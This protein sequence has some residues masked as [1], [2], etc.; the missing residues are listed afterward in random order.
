MVWDAQKGGNRK[1]KTCEGDDDFI[2]PNQ[3][4]KLS[5]NDDQ[6]DSTS[7]TIR[8]FALKKAF[9]QSHNRDHQ[10]CRE[11]SSKNIKIMNVQELVK[12]NVT[13]SRYDSG[14][15]YQ[16]LKI[17]LGSVIENDSSSLSTA[18]HFPL[19]YPCL[20]IKERLDKASETLL[21]EA[22]KAGLELTK[23]MRAE[24]KEEVYYFLETMKWRNTINVLMA[25]QYENF[26]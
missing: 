16:A 22:L 18:K 1:R 23:H 21:E 25:L 17:S 11:T 6:N 2:I 20:A 3:K 19:L 10:Q 9:D 13:P 5:L 4:Y 24:R 14:N 26:S 15:K 7:K 12:N 8:P